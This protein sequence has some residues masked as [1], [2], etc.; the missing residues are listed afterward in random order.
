[1]FDLLIKFIN[2][3]KKQQIDWTKEMSSFLYN[4]AILNIK[5]LPK[6]IHRNLKFNLSYYLI[7]YPLTQK[8]LKIYNKINDKNKLSFIIRQVIKNANKNNINLNSYI[9]IKKELEITKILFDNRYK[10]ESTDNLV[11]LKDLSKSLGIIEVCTDLLTKETINIL[12]QLIEKR[13][14][15]T[16]N[17]KYL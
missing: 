1:M 10:K 9:N 16:I 4:K 13:L 5:N 12:L 17:Y 7:Y 8:Q 6:N 3:A 2:I 11:K 15:L 14:F